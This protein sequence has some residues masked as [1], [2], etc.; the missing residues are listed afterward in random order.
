MSQLRR[1]LGIVVTLALATGTLISLGMGTV[2][3]APDAN[4]T[5]YPYLTDLVGTKVTINW[6]TSRAATSGAVS[7]G[8]AGSCTGHLAGA[9]R[10]TLSI[11]PSDVSATAVPEYQWRSTIDVGVPGTYC[12]KVWLGSIDLLGS[13]PAPQFT[14][15]VPAGSTQPFSFAV[16]GD[17]GSVDQNGANPD[18][19]NVLNQIANSG[20]RFAISTGDNAYNNGSQEDYGDL[21]QHF[22]PANPGN[23]SAVPPIPAT[24]QVGMSAVFGPSFWTVPG[25][26][27]PM[28]AA[29]GNHGFERADSACVAPPSIAACHPHIANWPQP[30][31]VATSSGRYTV[32]AYGPTKYGTTA[33]NMP[34]LWYAFDGGTARFYVLETAW[35]DNNKGSAPTPAGY[36][37]DYE[38]HWKP[39]TAEYEWL[40]ADLAT[41]PGGLKFAIFHKPLQADTSSANEASD[42]WLRSDGPAGNLSLES[43][44]AR[45]GVAIAF[46]GHAHIYERNTP[47]SADSLVSYVTGGGGAKPESVGGGTL[48]CSAND[49]YARSWS[50]TTSSGKACPST[51]PGAVAP[52]TS[53]AQA[54]HFLKVSVNGLQVKVDPTDS[55]GAVFDSQ[56]YNFSAAPGSGYTVDGFGG[57]HPFSV[58]GAAPL[59][60]TTGAPYWNNVD[61]ARGVALLPNKTGG[62]VLDGWGGLHPFA[63]NGGPMPPKPTGGPYWVGWDI[64]KSIAINPNGKSGF[65]MDGWGGMHPFSIDGTTMP[66]KPADSPY[67]QGFNIA[68]GVTLLKGGGG[69]TAD[70]WG[71]LHPFTI[72]NATAQPVP[73]AAYWQG[74]DIVRGVT[75]TSDDG[76]GYTIDGYGG[77]HGFVITKTPP[78]LTASS[79]YWPN[80]D[81]A[82]GGSL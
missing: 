17:W 26:S 61:I 38:A 51:G 79:G 47:H 62:Y 53:A 14:T 24:P 2:S 57:L 78:L 7:W 10:N 54:F 35:P 13:D 60:A 48:S 76:A 4:L 45:N 31:A 32:D 49:A 28:F 8:P 81:I 23:P 20:V 70:G 58:G 21:Q 18:E 64:A 55:T 39:G 42:T 69:Y 82:R 63:I 59:G 44:L 34:S 77:L 46:N 50:F 40:K 68:R 16:L 30:T 22:R 73:A 80:R 43:M 37:N 5:R 29:I 15:Q 52:P 11:G 9:T 36:A 27:I 56:T 3:A 71:G 1:L 74:W 19:A 41:H 65:V 75:V 12:Y 33:A 6:A 25:R 67:W 72:N 66:T